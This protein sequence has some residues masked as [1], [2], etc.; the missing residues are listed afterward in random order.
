MIRLP[1]LSCSIQSLSSRFS[2]QCVSIG[3]VH[4]I[5]SVFG[6]IRRSLWWAP[7][8]GNRPDNN[9]NQYS[10][11]YDAATDNEAKLQIVKFVSRWRRCWIYWY[12]GRSWCWIRGWNRN[13]AVR[14]VVRWNGVVGGN[15]RCCFIQLFVAKVSCVECGFWECE[16][17]GVI[18][19]LL[20]VVELGEE[21]L[22][23]GSS[24]SDV[25]LLLLSGNHFED[26][27][28]A[29]GSGWSLAVAHEGHQRDLNIL[30]SVIVEDDLEAYVRVVVTSVRRPV[31]WLT[32]YG[33]IT[34]L[35]SAIRT[36]PNVARNR[37]NLV[38]KR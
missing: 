38:S 28:I 15:N 24:E 34:E 19:V 9:S 29:P 37:V 5:F 26:Q 6:T 16:Y 32:P 21:A 14:S 23:K 8:K 35:S 20:V 7:A 27:N 33:R 3:L 30:V 18:W 11:A 17:H 4:Q 2:H 22:E 10:K 36:S 25:V 31:K 1:R 13:R 12:G